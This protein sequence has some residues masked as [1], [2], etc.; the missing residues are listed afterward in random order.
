MRL[1]KLFLAD[2]LEVTVSNFEEKS[3]VGNEYI[4]KQASEGGTFVAI[5]YTMKN[6]SDKPFRNVCIIQTH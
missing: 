3:T 2:Q 4:N 1:E 5:Q 6:I